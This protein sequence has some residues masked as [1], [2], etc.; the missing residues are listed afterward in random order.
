MYVSRNIEALTCNHC[1]SG[2]TVSIKYYGYVFVALGIQRAMRIHLIVLL[3]VA[4]LAVPYFSTLSHKW[5][6]FRKKRY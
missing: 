3:F 4:P 1:R 5:H 6:D 2:K